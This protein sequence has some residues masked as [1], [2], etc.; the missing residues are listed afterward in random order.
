[1][2]SDPPESRRAARG[3]EEAVGASGQCRVARL[4]LSKASKSLC[5]AN[6]QPF[7]FIWTGIPWYLLDTGNSAWIR[8]NGLFFFLLQQGLAMPE[9]W[10]LSLLKC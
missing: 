2:V 5:C 8:G 10:P 3:L 4:T 6:F 1:M 9:Q 7:L